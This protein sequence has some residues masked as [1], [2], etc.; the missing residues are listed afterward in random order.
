MTNPLIRPKIICLIL[1]FNFYTAISFSQFFLSADDLYQEAGEYILA[2]EYPEALPLY[3]QLLEKGCNNANIHY[4]IGQCYLNIP[5]QKANAIQHLEIAV[6]R[7][8]RNYKGDSPEEDAAPLHACYLLGMAYRINYQLEKSI[9]TFDLLLDSLNSDPAELIR[10]DEQ[11]K[12]CKN[13]GELIKNEISLKAKRLDDNINTPNSNF[14]PVVNQ[15]ETILFYMDALKFYNA[16]MQSEKLKDHWKKPDNLTPKIKSDGDYMVVD[17]SEDGNTILLR[18][19]DP[20]TKGDIYFC[21]KK[22]GRWDKIKKLN[23]NINSRFDE[24]HASFANNDQTL[25]F[26]S[27]RA[28]GYGGLDIYRSEIDSNGDWGP[29]LN[30]GPVINTSLDEESPFMSDDNKSLYFSSQG[31]FNMGGYDIFVSAINDDGELQNPQNIG[32][33]LNTTDND[34][35]FFPLKDGKQGYH[36]K[37]TDN[38]NGNM[39]IY[40][41]EILSIA[42]PVRFT[43]KG[44]IT[45]P[46]QSPVLFENID[47]TLIDKIQNDTI[48]TNKAEKNGNYLYRLPSGEFELDFSTEGFVLDKKNVS[49]PQYLNIEELVVNS[50]LKY[51]LAEITDTN[52]KKDMS[53]P[54][55]TEYASAI[56]TFVLH[57]VL[58]GFDKYL[59]SKANINFLKGLVTL[60]K[61]YPDIIVSIDGYTDAIGSESYNRA[62]SLKRAKQVAGFL[63]SSDI[64]QKRILVN[65]YGEESPVAINNNADGSD[66]PDGRKYNRRAEISLDRIPDN[67]FIIKKVNIPETLQ[68][69]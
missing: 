14:N 69:R 66:N 7:A 50:D 17:V 67:L 26:T 59:I 56:D 44:H 15:S 22:N 20:Y 60:L 21:K 57:Y 8:T 63:S 32:Y 42:N 12:L 18:L 43:I 41:Y 16:I 49:L 55:K 24:T 52:V 3:I 34:L 30:L 1:I 68:V 29:A 31:H 6:K 9:Q 47:I 53:V 65:G 62:L 27:N 39:D 51:E 28:G 13:A 38:F 23:A 2:D 54:V 4:K 45:L 40:R 46:P 61:K 35:F 64:G 19:D 11:I 25:Y 37:Y 5:G 36:A 48:S 33:P 58:F 10:I